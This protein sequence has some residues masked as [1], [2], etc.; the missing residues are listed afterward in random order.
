MVNVLLIS[1]QKRTTNQM[2]VCGK[3]IDRSKGDRMLDNLH[4]ITRKRINIVVSLFKY[5]THRRFTFVRCECSSGNAHHQLNEQVYFQRIFKLT[6]R[7]R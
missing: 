2:L 3:G 7:R 4:D 1:P 5:V 6:R